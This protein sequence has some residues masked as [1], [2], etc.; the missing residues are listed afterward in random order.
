[1]VATTT[2]SRREWR[3]PLVQRL[4]DAN[5][6]RHPEQIVEEYT[7][8]LRAAAGQ[9]KLPIRVD[10]IASLKGI[11]RRT[12]D[13]NFA[14]RIY[15]EDNGQLVMDISSND[16]DERQR[17]TE[18]H[19]LTHTAFPGFSEEHRFRTDAPR[20]E[21]HPPNREEEYLCDYGAAALLMPR[22]LVEGRYSVKHG[23]DDVER[24]ASDAQV[25]IEAAANRLVALSDEPAVLLCLVRM[26]KPADR[27]A[28]RRGEAAP[29]R[30]RVR[31]AFSR[32]VDVY[33]PRYKSADDDSLFYRAARSAEV[34]DGTEQLPG[35]A[36]GLYRLTA[37][38]YGSGDVERVL[39]IGRPTA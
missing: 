5:G 12:G 35:V 39:A 22:G 21:R 7:D 10:H 1:M 6:G 16:S 28:L 29:P 27:P 23:L 31:Y 38:R 18:A 3:E 9:D 13:H 4:I 15:V 2:T 17:F 24:L 33:V 11:R 26:N 14:G 37:K 8:G 25:S 32:H 20:M 19:E 34:E 36:A 30:L